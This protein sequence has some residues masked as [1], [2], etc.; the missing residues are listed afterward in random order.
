MRVAWAERR[1]VSRQGTVWPRTHATVL[2]VI[3]PAPN[4]SAARAGRG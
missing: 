4:R 3:S 2:V 1:E